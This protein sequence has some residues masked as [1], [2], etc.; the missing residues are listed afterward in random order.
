MHSAHLRSIVAAVLWLPVF[1]CADAPKVAARAAA[2]RPV[3]SPADSA[4]YLG[5]SQGCGFLPTNLN[6]DPTALV[7]EYIRRDNQGAFLKSNP[8]LDSAY[9]CPDHLPG[10]DAFTVVVTSTI[11]GQTITDSVATV[12]VQSHV[13]GDMGQDSIGSVFEAKPRVAVDTFVVVSTPFGWRIRSP[14]LPDNVLG[15]WVLSRPD[16]IRL[17]PSNRDSLVEAIRAASSNER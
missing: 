15:S 4:Y 8:W 11:V 1:A 16:W 13:L 12:L 7:R 2:R 6:P 10:P 17:R 9:D 3:F 14:Q 5:P